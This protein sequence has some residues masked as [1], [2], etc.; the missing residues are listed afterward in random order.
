MTQVIVQVLQNLVLEGDDTSFIPPPVRVGIFTHRD[1]LDDDLDA[2]MLE[3]FAKEPAD[4]PSMKKV[5]RND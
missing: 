2:S 3:L 4:T 1:S 5:G